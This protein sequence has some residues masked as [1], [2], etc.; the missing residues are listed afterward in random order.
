M[1]KFKKCCLFSQYD[2]SQSNSNNP[3]L[4]CKHFFK[5]NISSFAVKKSLEFNGSINLPTI[6]QP[7]ILDYKLGLNVIFIN[8]PSFESRSSRDHFYFI[9]VWFNLKNLQYFLKF[10]DLIQ[11]F[12]LNKKPEKNRKKKQY[13]KQLPYISSLQDIS[14]LKKYLY[15]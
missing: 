3:D 8:F 9:R 6:L 10:P 14:H 12:F 7:I 2:R 11:Y 4:N 13:K 5:N 15:V 1:V